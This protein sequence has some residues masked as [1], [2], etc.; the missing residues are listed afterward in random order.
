MWCNIQ[1]G[2]CAPQTTNAQKLFGT[3]IIQ[4]YNLISIGVTTPTGV[5]SV[6]E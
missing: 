1:C 3:D 6:V 4:T 5:P 2:L